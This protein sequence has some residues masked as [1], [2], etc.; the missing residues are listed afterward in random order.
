MLKAWGE[1]LLARLEA[2]KEQKLQE[3]QTEQS[4]ANQLLNPKATNA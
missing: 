4:G 1:S 2:S 3:E